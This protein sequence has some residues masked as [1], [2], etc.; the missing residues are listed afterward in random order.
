[1]LLTFRD[2]KHALEAIKYNNHEV[3]MVIFAKFGIFS[4]YTTKNNK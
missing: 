4:N 3:G 2:G 1:M